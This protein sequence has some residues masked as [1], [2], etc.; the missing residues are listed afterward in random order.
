MSLHTDAIATLSALPPNPLRDRFLDHLAAHPDGAY[1]SCRPDHLTASVLVLSAD[2][3]QVLLTLHAKARQWF[4]LGG[5]CEPGDQ[6]LASA[7]LREATEESGLTGLALHP[8]PIHLDEHA[9]P[10]CR[11][12]DRVTAARNEHAAY[13]D[14]VTHHLDVRFLAIAGPETAHEV[15]AESLDVRW[16]PV[17]ALPGQDLS[18]S[19]LVAAALDVVR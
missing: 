18:V 12:A 6:T 19:T 15:S 10:F 3:R 2:H 11:S 9:V 13:R 8:T 7:A 14:R 5:H 17:D 1:R 16:W 4:Q